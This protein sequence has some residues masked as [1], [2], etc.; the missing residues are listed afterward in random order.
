MLRAQCA[1]K[2]I[3]QVMDAM[4]STAAWAPLNLGARNTGVNYI[5]GRSCVISLLHA[6]TD[7]APF[8][9]F[10]RTRAKPGNLT[11]CA[12]AISPR[13][14][15]LPS[16]LRKSCVHPVA[17]RRRRVPVPGRAY[18]GPIGSSTATSIALPLPSDFHFHRTSTSIDLPLSR[19]FFYAHAQI[20]FCRMSVGVHAWYAVFQCIRALGL[21]RAIE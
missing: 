6:I 5:H 3:V 11:R 10:T 14:V 15:P 19:P 17:S 18:G 7:A 9:H 16:A 2:S 20:V 8:H 13:T 4:C 12:I 21:T 1:N